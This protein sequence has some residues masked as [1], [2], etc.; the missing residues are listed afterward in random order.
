MQLFLPDIPERKSLENTVLFRAVATKTHTHTHCSPLA[1]DVN[2]SIER[3]TGLL[4]TRSLHCRTDNRL[5]ILTAILLHIFPHTLLMLLTH[6]H[7]QFN[8][9]HLCRQRTTCIIHICNQ[10]A[11]TVVSCV[12]MCVYLCG[13]LRVVCCT[14][15]P[16]AVHL[17]MELPVTSARYFL[18]QS[19]DYFVN[20]VAVNKAGCPSKFPRAQG[21]V[22]RCFFRLKA[23][24]V[25]FIIT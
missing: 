3:A 6:T 18:H 17:T 4:P 9:T 5:H 2:A 1:P 10:H 15:V 19:I 11:F 14:C 13:P 12:H 7:A 22:F 8:S 21:D 20:K 16:A 24:A 25:K 23:K